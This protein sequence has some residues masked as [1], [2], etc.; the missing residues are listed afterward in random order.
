MYKLGPWFWFGGPTIINLAIAIAIHALVNRPFSVAG[1][2]LNSRGFVLMG[3][4]SFG[5]YLWQQPLTFHRKLGPV[6]IFPINII[7]LLALA[8]LGY[9]LIE[10]P[11]Q[12]YGRKIAQRFSNGPE[13]AAML[14][15]PEVTGQYTG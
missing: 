10:R 8:A 3:T 13:R 9:Y 14:A 7:V 1:R 6:G 5:L 4:W 12:R 11:A 2:I 15:K